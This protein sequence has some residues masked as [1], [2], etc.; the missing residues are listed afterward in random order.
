VASVV[1]ILVNAEAAKAIAELQAV[2]GE[3]SAIGRTSKT[4]GASTT[5]MGKA[6][7]AG[8]VVAAGGLGV[9]ALGLKESV[10]AASDAQSTQI[11]LG[12]AVQN[13]GLSWKESQGEIEEWVVKASGMSGFMQTDLNDAISNFVRTTKDVPSALHLT[14]LAMDVARTKGMSLSATQSLLARVY[15]GS[16][17]GL[18][19]LGIAVT[20]VTAAQDALAASAGRLTDKQTKE[21]ASAQKIVNSL[22]KRVAAGKTLTKAEATELSKANAR[23]SALRALALAHGKVTDEQKKQAKETDMLATRQSALSQVQKA[24]GGQAKAYADSA[25]GAQDRLKASVEELEIQIGSGLLP[26]VTSFIEKLTSLAEFLGHNSEET[27]AFGIGLG[28][29][30]SAFLAARVAAAVANSSLVKFAKSE[31]VAALASRILAVSMMGIPIVAIV[32]GIIAIGVALVVLYKK[33]QTFRNIVNGAFNAVK[34]VASAVADFIRSH[35]QALLILLTGPLGAAVVAASRHWGT[36]KSAASSA[37]EPVIEV[38]S[39]LSGW[40]NNVIGAIQQVIHWLSQIHVPSIDLP[41]I[42]GIASGAASFRGGTAVVGEAGAEIVGLRAG[43]PVMNAPN[44]RAYRR[45][46]RTAGGEGRRGRGN[47]TVVVQ[48]GPLDSLAA[49]R[50]TGRM[51]ADEVMKTLDRSGRET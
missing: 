2:K 25:A 50:R 27:K 26:V 17:I 8:T 48:A 9:L 12:K 22:N 3:I 4:A 33:S 42:P 44:T 45:D 1:Q 15:N 13:A 20:P 40:L 32:A 29:L 19:R 6:M 51:I 46:W 41:N 43:T 11:K 47:V 31:R 10:D 34:A 24:F 5:G 14:S 28:L 7:K 23:L 38:V 49:R 30:A 35:W 21:Q 16:Y 37:I 36:I 18:K 39:R